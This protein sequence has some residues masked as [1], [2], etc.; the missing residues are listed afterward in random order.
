M[1]LGGW[2]GGGGE[3]RQRERQR[4]RERD[5]ERQRQRETLEMV[6]VHRRIMVRVLI[7]SA[8]TMCIMGE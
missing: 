4:E 8:V 6:C 3:D 5:R 7:S 1:Q 2:G